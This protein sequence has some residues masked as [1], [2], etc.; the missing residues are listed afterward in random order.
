[1]G[2]PMKYKMLSIATIVLSVL[3]VGASA[4][5]PVKIDFYY[6]GLCP[7]CEDTFLDQLYPTYQELKDIMDVSINA[8]GNANYYHKE[9]GGWL[10][11]CQHGQTECRINMMHACAHLSISDFDLEM[12]FVKCTLESDYPANAGPQCAAISN[13]DWTPIESCWNSRDG[14]EA[15]HDVAVKQEQLNPSLYFVP[16][17]TVNDYF[18]EDQVGDCQTDMM[19]VVCDAY[20]GPAL[21]ACRNHRHQ[22]KNLSRHSPKM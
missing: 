7:Y 21:A 20:T 22:Y 12:D 9:G 17:I 11:T 14:E 18:S 5:D 2:L 13:V 6:E 19:A 1:M 3:L 15:L 4:Q 10:F 16:W 8:F